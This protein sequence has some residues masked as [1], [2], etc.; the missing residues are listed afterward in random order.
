MSRFNFIEVKKVK[1]GGNFRKHPEANDDA[2]RI[3][4]K[5]VIIGKN[6]IR[7]F[8]K[9]SGMPVSIQKDADSVA[10][11]MVKVVGK[12]PAHKVFKF[13]N[14]KGQSATITR[15]TLLA[16]M[17][18]GCYLADLKEDGVFVLEA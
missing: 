1:T 16:D 4:S 9:P 3:T 17:P 6:L 7:K 8:R 18:N 13:Q 5:S 14:H 2:I 12:V 11:K 10:L 15:P